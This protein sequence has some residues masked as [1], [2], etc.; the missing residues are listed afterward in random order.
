MY[1]VDTNI[2]LEALLEQDRDAEVNSFLES[3][4]LSTI[5]IT[6][7]S[8]YSIG[9]LLF[10][11]KKLALFA[12]FLDETVLDGV[13][14]RSLSVEDLKTLT[15]P[16][17]KFN[18]DFEDAYQYTV[19]EKFNLQLI[20]FDRDFDRTDRKRKTPAEVLT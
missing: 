12:P 4:N 3:I 7:M 15:Q 2:F 16:I 5:Y 13:G 19:A 11:L 14:V 6:D 1:L 9:I 20:S 8:L 10:R 18:L 17:Q